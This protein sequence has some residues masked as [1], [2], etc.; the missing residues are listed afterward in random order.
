MPNAKLME[1]LS[2]PIALDAFDSLSKGSH[3][4]SVLA[5]IASDVAVRKIHQLLGGVE[6]VESIRKKKDDGIIDAEFKVIN[7]TPKKESK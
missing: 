3:P 1:L 7:V 6:K 4:K 5:G 2:H